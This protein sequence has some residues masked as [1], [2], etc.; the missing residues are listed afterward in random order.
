M[1]STAQDRLDV[2]HQSFSSAFRRRAAD[3][4]EAA[5]ED[6]ADAVLDNI[7]RLEVA[8]LSAARQALDKTGPQI[9]SAYQA[10]V[11]AKK[12]VDDAYAQ[13]K[14]LAER[15]RMVGDLAGKVGTLV[16]KASGSGNS[17]AA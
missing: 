4:K 12:K 1:A 6:E 3:L 15:I 14:K 9:E 17:Q 5:S 10:A 16:S 8:F 13:A 7:A 11:D 2:I